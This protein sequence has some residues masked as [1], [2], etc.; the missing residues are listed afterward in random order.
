ME[1]T[2]RAELLEILELH[3]EELEDIIGTTGDPEDLDKRVCDC[4]SFYAWTAGNVYYVHEPDDGWPPDFHVTSLSRHPY[5]DSQDVAAFIEHA[6]RPDPEPET[7][8]QPEPLDRHFIPGSKRTGF[9]GWA[10]EEPPDWAKPYLP[11]S[12]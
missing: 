7:E 2:L 4:T 9:N 5:S 6:K 12:E 8:P 3:G 1:A 11:A 10:G